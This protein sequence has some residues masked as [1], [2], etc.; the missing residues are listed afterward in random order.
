MLTIS[1]VL[2]VSLQNIKRASSNKRTSSPFTLIHSDIWGPSSVPNISRAS[3]L[4]SLLMILPSYMAISFETKAKVSN[5]FPTFYNMIKKQFGISFKGLDQTMPMIFSI[6]P[7]LFF[8]Q[9]KGI[10][11]ESSCPYTPQ[12]NGVA[13]RKNDHLL[14]VTRMLLFHH[15]VPKH[16]WG[17]VALTTTILINKLPSQ[18]LKSHSPIELLTKN[19]PN[20]HVTS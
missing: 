5:I 9:H 19:F 8:F 13:R 18:T 4:L 3:G 12:Q 2:C 1:I 10:I 20:F 7:P 6:N 14:A 11:H 15:N 16:Y 17:K